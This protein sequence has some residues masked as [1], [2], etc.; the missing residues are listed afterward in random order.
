MRLRRMLLIVLGAAL[1]AAAPTRAAE[2]FDRGWRFGSSV[3]LPAALNIETSYEFGRRSVYLCGG[4]WGSD[5]RGVHGGV[6]LER[7]GT[8]RKHFA[9]NVVGGSFF[10]RDGDYRITKFNYG[11]IEPYFRY[12][13]FFVAPVLGFGQG[14][15]EDRDADGLAVFGRLGFSWRL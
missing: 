3:G 13:A 7:G 5:V 15:E 2:P 8:A 9:V 14:T 10:F 1:L 6:T 11:G 12:R 4:Y